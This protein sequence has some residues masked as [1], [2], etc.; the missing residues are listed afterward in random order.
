LSGKRKEKL[1]LFL[2]AHAHCGDQVKPPSLS[3]HTLY[4]NTAP[5]ELH[6]IGHILGRGWSQ[7]T[8]V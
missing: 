8:I 3:A 6:S 4:Y 7:R 2:R 1:S 5:R